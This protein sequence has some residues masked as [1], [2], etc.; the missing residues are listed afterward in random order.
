MSQADLSSAG[1]QVLEVP[2]CCRRL[3][4]LRFL[5]GHL[6]NQLRAE[7]RGCWPEAEGG[8]LHWCV[9]VR[10]RKRGTERERESA[11]MS[12]RPRE[13]APQ[14]LLSMKVDEQELVA[15]W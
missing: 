14:A 6:G 8:P 13:P 2:A 7:V 9:C 12:Q 10:K 3:A 11:H 5:R 4:L 1:S 15:W